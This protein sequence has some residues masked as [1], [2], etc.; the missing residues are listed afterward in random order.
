MFYLNSN[1]LSAYPNEKEIL[2]QDGVEYEVIECDYITKTL[3]REGRV[4]SKKVAL[5]KLLKKN[6]KYSSM[7]TIVRY[8]KLE[9]C[10]EF[11]QVF[12]FG[13]YFTIL[14]VAGLSWKS[15]ALGK[16]SA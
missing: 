14:D 7:S 11:H 6:D 1:E 3:N 8:M 13:Q 10:D 15:F 16:E 9:K 4:F 2:L 5:V 12:S